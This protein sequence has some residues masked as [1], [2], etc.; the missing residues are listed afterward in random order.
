MLAEDGLF[1]G[2]PNRGFRRGKWFVVDP[3]HVRIIHGERL[4][5]RVMALWFVRRF[6]RRNPIAAKPS[7]SN[8]EKFDADE[9]PTALQAQ[10]SS[11]GSAGSLP[12]EDDEEELTQDLLVASQ[13]LP[14]EQSLSVRHPTH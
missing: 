5:Q 2:F 11:G 8:A 12:P 10:P 1:R 9:L 6:A 13:V 3:I 7:P 4:G 14:F